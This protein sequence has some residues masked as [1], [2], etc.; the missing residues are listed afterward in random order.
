MN[1]DHVS[2]KVSTYDRIANKYASK[3]RNFAPEKERERFISF[4]PKGGHILDLG[5]AAGRDSIYFSSRG[6]HAVGVDLSK[7]LLAIARKI[8]PNLTFLHRDIRHLKL[9][10]SSFDGI[11]ACAVL[12]HLKR[13]EV[14]GVLKNCYKKLKPGGTLFVLVK[15]G[16]GEAD[17]SEK[18]SSGESRHFV[19]YQS[20]EVQKMLEDAG[21]SVIDLYTWNSSD[22]DAS[23]RDVEWISCF[24]KKLEDSSE[25]N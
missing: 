19:Y 3:I 2:K 12:L 13:K 24:A 14:L 1:D 9:P 17:V 15:K 21:L 6:F 16:D 18:L 23:S 22:R 10:D 11:W 20:D 8:A 4:L 25:I 7:K 5:C